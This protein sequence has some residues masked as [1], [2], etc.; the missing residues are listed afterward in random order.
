MSAIFDGLGQMENVRAQESVKPQ[1]LFMGAD[2]SINLGKEIYPV[3]D[4]IGS[5]WVIEV[6]GQTKI[7]PTKGGTLN[8]KVTP[9]LKL[10]AIS[11]TVADFKH[12]RGYTFGNDPNVRLTRAMTRSGVENADYHAALNQAIAVQNGTL[13]ATQ[14]AIN[15]KDQNGDGTP[16]HRE[17]VIQQ[18]IEIAEQNLATTSA[19]VGSDL[20][21]RNSLTDGVDAMEVNFDV[22]SEKQLQNPY[23]ITMTRFHPKDGAPRMV[24]DLVYA[25]SLN[26]IDS[27]VTNVHFTEGGF[28]PNF[29]L[30]DFQM[31]LY[32]RGVEVATSVSSKRV[33]LTVDEAFE[34]VKMEYIG[35]HPRETRP[36]EPAMGVLPA[37]LP[38][39]LATGK[40][41]TLIFVRVSKDGLA[42][43]AFLDAACT[44]R[45]EDP[46][47]DS[48]VKS[49]RFDP[50]LSNG[51]AVEGI[52]SIRLN[53][54]RI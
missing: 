52:A 50:A 45:T 53:Q 38:E 39:R 11:A 42:D 7:I 31:H 30:V 26:P 40:Y 15:L 22:S 48:V 21:N 14:M 18:T 17:P 24:Q 32:N 43:E 36:P 51:K 13:A 29:E 10:S 28:P 19:E 46:F 4:V 54:L 23:V 8:I 44:K 3:K 16:R 41:S 49:M 6:N 1:T 9:S 12:E 5:S 20:S 35:A 33:E 34:Y 25:R 2:V 27:H 37:E 47:L